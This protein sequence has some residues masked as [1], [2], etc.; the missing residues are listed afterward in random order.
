MIR[1]KQRR[2]L[3]SSLRKSHILDKAE[4]LFWQKG[5]HSTSMKD[6]SESC[7]CKPANIYNYFES[8]EDILFE[9][10]RDITFQTLSKVKPLEEDTA[11]SPV[12]QLRKFINGHF[13]MMVA[14][15]KTTVLISDT[16]LKELSVEHRKAVIEM[17]DKYDNILRKI[18]Q[19]GKDSGDFRDADSQIISYLISSMIV[20]SNIWYSARGRLSAEEISK[21][22]FD[23]VYNGIKSG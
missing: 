3:R 9:V 20:R 16:G 7:G 23:F 4:N 15:K 8:K 18:L 19:R 5:Y 1:T 10:I 22:I 21:I 11:A 12:E 13:G 17:R 14:M 6:I 2:E